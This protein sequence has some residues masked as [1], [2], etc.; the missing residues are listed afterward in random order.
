MVFTGEGK[1]KTTA[2]LGQIVR[3]LGW[4]KK[5]ILVQFLKGMDYGEVKT[6]KR[7][8]V[9]IIQSGPSSLSHSLQEIKEQDLVGKAFNKLREEVAREKYDLVVLDELNWALHYKLLPW[10]EVRTFLEELKTQCDVVSTGRNA[11]RELV[12]MADCVTEMKKI[13][14]HYDKGELAK[15]GREF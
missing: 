11:P 12:E 15:K 5:V 1:G 14:H 6:L 9:K 10:R 8:G 2:A 3:A 13:K 7:L 4:G